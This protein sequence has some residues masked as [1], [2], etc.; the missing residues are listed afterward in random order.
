M[1]SAISAMVSHEAAP[2][3]SDPGGVWHRTPRPDPWLLLPLTGLAALTRRPPLSAATYL[4]ACGVYLEAVAWLPQ[5]HLLDCMT[6][7]TTA[8]GQ[9]DSFVSSRRSAPFCAATSSVYVAALLA[10]RVLSV[11]A[12]WAS[13]SGDGGSGAPVPG[14]EFAAGC[15]HTLLLLD[16]CRVAC[17]RGCRRRLRDGGSGGGDA[18]LN[19]FWTV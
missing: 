17:L 16:F 1:S 6:T 14:A 19:C 9:S 13:G 2:T 10:N 8:M 7:T 12:R 5:L 18:G 4:R 15:L 11:L 3:D